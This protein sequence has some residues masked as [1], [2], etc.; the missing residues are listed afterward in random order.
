MILSSRNF[1]YALQLQST[2]T[3]SFPYLRHPMSLFKVFFSFQNLFSS[4]RTVKCDENDV[5]IFSHVVRF[6]SSMESLSK[7]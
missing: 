5:E 4:V 2:K 1:E 7:R 3:I 6:I